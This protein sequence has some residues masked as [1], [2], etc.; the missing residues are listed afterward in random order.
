MLEIGKAFGQ[1]AG[2][3]AVD[4]R[5]GCNTERRLLPFEARGLEFVPEHVTH[6]LRPVLISLLTDQFI[7]LLGKVFIQRNGEAIH[8]GVLLSVMDEMLPKN[9]GNE[10]YEVR[11]FVLGVY[12]RHHAFY[13]MTNYK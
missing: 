8:R 6:G 7:E 3:V 11:K 10:T 13:I 2:M 4:I 5:E 1:V 12:R 9:V